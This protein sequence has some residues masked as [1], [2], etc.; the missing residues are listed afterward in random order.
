MSGSKGWFSVELNSSE[1]TITV[2]PEIVGGI[3]QT[4]VFVRVPPVPLNTEWL[5]R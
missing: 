4:L 5:Y 3:A 2:N 1:V